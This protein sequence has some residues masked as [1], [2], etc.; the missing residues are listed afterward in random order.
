[1][2]E[3]GKVVVNKDE[4]AIVKIERHS[5]C[6]K[7]NKKCELAEDNKNDEMLVEVDNP[8]EA[9]EGQLV[10]LEMADKNLTLS[11]L[12]IYLFPLVSLVLGY[13]VGSYLVPLQGEI[14]GILGAISFFGI[15]ALLIKIIGS[16]M[17]V[18]PRITRVVSE[19]KNNSNEFSCH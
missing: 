1:M 7:C 12:L 15:S 4:S 14:S 16:R 6:S 13:F 18:Q 5:A 3:I 9:V 17:A 8:V 11:A 2:E 19:L 10:S